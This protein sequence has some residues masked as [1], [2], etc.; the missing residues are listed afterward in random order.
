MPLALAWSFIWFV[1]GV[2]CAFAWMLRESAL[3]WEANP[4]MRVIVH[5][6]GMGSAIVLRLTTLAIGMIMVLKLGFR[7]KG[8]AVILAAHAFL[9]A[10]YLEI[11]LRTDL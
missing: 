7:T 6:Y 8:T 3:R 11:V 10:A 1:T 2:D 9:F 4:L 5:D